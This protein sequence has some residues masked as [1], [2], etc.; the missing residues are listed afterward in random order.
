[1]LHSFPSYE[2]VCFFLIFQ[3]S[4]STHSQYRI[5]LFTRTLLLYGGVVLLPPHTYYTI[6]FILFLL[7]SPVLAAAPDSLLS[8]LYISNQCILLFLFVFY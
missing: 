5:F 1:M 7:N 2:V 3:Y 4:L 6:I 8:P